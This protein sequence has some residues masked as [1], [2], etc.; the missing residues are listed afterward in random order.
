MRFG[1][2]IPT[3]TAFPRVTEEYEGGTRIRYERTYELCRMAEKLGYDFGTIGQHRFSPEV[4]DASAPLIVLAA[5]AQHT[6]TL[7]LCTNIALLPTHPPI[8]FAEQAAT[9]DEVSSGRLIVGLGLG[10]RAYEYD[11]VGVP[12]KERTGRLEEGVAIVRR[13]WAK[14]AF[15]YQGEYYRVPNVEVMPKPLQV[16]G[17][18]I[19][20]GA[21]AKPAVRRAARIGDG[22][23]TDNIQTVGALAP[24]IARFKAESAEHGNKGE[25]A[26]IRKV[27]IAPTRKQVEEEWFPDILK[28][29]QTYT[30]VNVQFENKQFETALKSGRPMRL[31]EFPD[32]LFIAGRPDECIAQIRQIRE[33]TGC[34]Y[35]VADFGRAAHGPEYER[36]RGMVE[37]FGR[38][39]IPA[40]S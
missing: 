39:V 15:D 5:L 18:P 21:I 38:E 12:Y 35:I 3:L 13:A 17:P 25:V 32:D 7:R 28:A 34:D 20:I 37:L 30:K 29:Y 27:G 19:W 1:F 16:G 9:V 8:D 24:Q 2:S 11:A 23:L 22:W 31:S 4:I 36:L 10:Y 26:L 6:E 40:F 14:G 33:K